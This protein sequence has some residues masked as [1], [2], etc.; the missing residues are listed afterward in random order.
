MIGLTIFWCAIGGLLAFLGYY[1][2]CESRKGRKYTVTGIV[3]LIIGILV[4]VGAEINL[5]LNGTTE[6]LMWFL[7]WT[8]R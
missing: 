2:I 5:Y 4:A 8:R 3:L 7:L 6:E 1:L